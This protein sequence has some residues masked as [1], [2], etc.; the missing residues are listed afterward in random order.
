MRL[1]FPLQQMSNLIIVIIFNSINS[2]L[3]V[4][5]ILHLCL[6][7]IRINP[8]ISQENKYVVAP[9]KHTFEVIYL[10]SM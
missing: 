3:I 7:N 8:D 1:I 4:A 5:K 10:A 9:D 6:I 2:N